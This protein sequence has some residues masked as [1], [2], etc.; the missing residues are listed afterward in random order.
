MRV[1]LDQLDLRN[2]EL[3][4]PGAPESRLR[5]A[6]AT[7]VGG[8]LETGG[9]RLKLEAL[10]AKALVLASVEL[11][12]SSLRLSALSGATL[13]GVRASYDAKPGA[14]T[15]AVA[16][17]ALVAPNFAV[18]AGS[19]RVS[20]EIELGSV[21]VGVRGSDG[22]IAAKQVALR[23][24]RITIDDFE[25]SADALEGTDVT[26]SWGAEGIR[27]S[28][29]TA[30]APTADLS[31]AFAPAAAPA[32][33]SRASTPPPVPRAA[34]AP[35]FDLRTLDR[36][37]GDV[38]VDLQVDLTLP[39][40]GPRRATHEFRVRVDDGALDF[41]E[42]ENDLATLENALL[43]FAVREGG[44]VL[45]R[46]IPLL[47]TRGHGKPI[48]RWDLSEGDL[49]LARR[50]RVR[51]AV[52][53][54]ARIVREPGD[55]GGG[56]SSL[57]AKLALKNLQARLSL[58]P[59]DA[60]DGGRIRLTKVGS[61]EARGNLFYEPSA[62]PRAGSVAIDVRALEASIA[63]MSLGSK[64]LAVESLVIGHAHPVELRFAGVAPTSV[65]ARLVDTALTGFRI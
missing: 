29:G 19:V 24:F 31:L 1:T 36:L 16:A 3:S 28:A 22:E 59:G 4:L 7:E 52:L 32:P 58:A 8:A 45:E 49:D 64:V 56:S 41:M 42:L 26:L 11:A 53:P 25:L 20:A 35:L 63:Q 46:G 43:D 61:L 48:V 30:S 2:L 65:S 9:D 54:K 37:A 13:R 33:G 14:T 34:T 38:D 21:T 27:L 62:A 60:A 5:V 47:P 55:D 12:T 15:L 51:L 44:L 40:L 50:N 23:N 17:D 39:I 10:R 18:T 57:L 6:S